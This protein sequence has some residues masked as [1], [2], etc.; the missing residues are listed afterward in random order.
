[1]AVRSCSLMSQSLRS[2]R[3]DCCSI[4]ERLSTLVERAVRRWL[5]LMMMSRYS[6]CSSGVRSLSRRIWAKPRMEEMGVLN[7]WEKL[8][9]KSERSS[10]TEESSSVMR[11][12]FLPSWRKPSG[13][14]RFTRT[15]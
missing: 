14:R 10:S 8:L 3:M 1:M 6:A 12:N 11:L 2:V 7:S 4:L 9:M 13:P 5:S 15:L